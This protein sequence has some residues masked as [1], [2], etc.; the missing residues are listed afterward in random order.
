MKIELETRNFIFDSIFLNF[1]FQIHYNYFL[2]YCLSKSNQTI[3][4]FSIFCLVIE[5]QGS[6]SKIK[7][8]ITSKFFF[9]TK[10]YIIYISYSQKDL[11]GRQKR[12]K[13]ISL[14]LYY[15]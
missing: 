5:D 10:F 7:I 12:T 3:P 4:K 9:L 15:N 1:K 8:I 11:P 13:K 14:F 6:V 2:L